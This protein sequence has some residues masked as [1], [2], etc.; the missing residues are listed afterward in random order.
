MGHTATCV[1]VPF[2]YDRETWQTAVS[3]PEKDDE[4]VRL[5]WTVNGT[6]NKIAYSVH[7]PFAKVSAYLAQPESENLFDT[8]FAKR[9]LVGSHPCH[10]GLCIVHIVLETDEV[11]VDRDCCAEDARSMRAEVLR[12]GSIAPSTILHASFS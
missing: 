6:K 3:R 9:Q 11:N 1:L 4:F 10:Q 12:F 5:R 7:S 2:G 8:A